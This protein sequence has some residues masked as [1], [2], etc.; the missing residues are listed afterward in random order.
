LASGTGL[1]VLMAGFV[2]IRAIRRSQR[3]QYSLAWCTV[4]MLAAAVGLLGGLHWYY[5]ERALAEARAE[6]RDTR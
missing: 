5:S 4:M 3:P 1:L 2:T 6:W